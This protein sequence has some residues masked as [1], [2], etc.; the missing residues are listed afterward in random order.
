[1]K[2]A[3]LRGNVEGDGESSEPGA[4][5]TLQPLYAHLLQDLLVRLINLPVFG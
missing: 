3:N 5:D 2:I 1:M 4:D